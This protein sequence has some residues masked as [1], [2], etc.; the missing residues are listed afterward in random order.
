VSSFQWAE[1]LQI[2]EALAA[3][4]LCAESE[5]RRRT[6]IGRAYYA[7]FNA[8]RAYAASVHGIVIG[9]SEGSVHG[10]LW[11]ELSFKPG[12]IAK[13]AN[14]GKQLH[15]LRKRADYEAT[16]PI[17]ARH[18]AEG[19]TLAKLAAQLLKEFNTPA[20]PASPST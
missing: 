1:F 5:G 11:H 12:K 16:P 18:M 19:L 4:G 2:A 3:D 7:T 17:S 20:A 13:L 10:K 15:T 9:A 8:A 6:V 14:H